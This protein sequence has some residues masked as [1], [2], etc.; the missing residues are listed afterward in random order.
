MKFRIV[1]WRVIKTV[2]RQIFKFTVAIVHNIIP[3][4][5]DLL[6]GFFK[7]PQKHLRIHIFILT[8]P[9][10]SEPVVPSP[11]L[12]ASIDFAVTIFKNNFNVKLRKCSKN[13]EEVLPDA[14][15]LTALEPGCG[16]TSYGQEFGEAGD[17]FNRHLAGWKG[18]ANIPF[19]YPITV[20]IVRNVQGTRGCSLGPVTDYIVIDPEGLQNVNTLA[21]ELGHACNLWH[22]AKKSNIMYHHFTRA[23][24][25]NWFQCN[26][27]RSCRHV[28]YY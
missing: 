6:L 25:S 24:G 4:G 2:A 17:Y 7:W 23:N 21:H 22:T 1:V 20:Y 18:F 10:T 16:I 12:K 27:F 19:T 14:V 5:P 26:I 9:L 13:W 11:A 15:P 28:N 3:N 8:D